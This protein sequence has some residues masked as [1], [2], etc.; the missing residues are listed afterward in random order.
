MEDTNLIYATTDTHFCHDRTFLTNPRGFTDIKSH[1]EAIIKN[2]NSIV[3]PS[4][5]VYLLGDAVLNNDEE[6]IECLRQLNGTIYLAIGNHDTDGRIER[7]REAGVFADIQYAYRLQ[8]KKFKFFLSHYPTLTANP[9]TPFPIFNISGH[10][11]SQDKF[12]NMDKL[13][14]NASLDA[15]NNTPVS[16]DEIIADIKAYRS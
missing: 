13:I 1:N 5:T 3:K 10:T 15:H 4:D 2:W 6:G 7:Y 8:Y 16:L 14:Y 11:H 9:G 12:E